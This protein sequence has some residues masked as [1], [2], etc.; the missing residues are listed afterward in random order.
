[1]R[2]FYNVTNGST[3]YKWT[4]VVL[5]GISNSI[6]SFIGEYDIFEPDRRIDMRIGIARV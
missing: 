3:N 4:L 2:A 5:P 1:M 6:P